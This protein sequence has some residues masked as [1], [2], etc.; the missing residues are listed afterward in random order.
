MVP[1]NSS[2]GGVQ[3]QT[4]VGATVTTT[5]E[6]S[7][8]TF[9]SNP[10]WMYISQQNDS[11]FGSTGMGTMGQ[12]GHHA[13][14]R[15]TFNGTDYP[16]DSGDHVQSSTAYADNSTSTYDTDFTVENELN[17]RNLGL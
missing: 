12:A 7:N 16:A 6:A 15:R 3:Y 17:N 13:T 9:G 5:T 2:N 11:P 10:Y 8:P 14:F 1:G 4:N